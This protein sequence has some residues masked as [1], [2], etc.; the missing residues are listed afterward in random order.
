[1]HLLMLHASL[2]QVC[3]VYVSERSAESAE[4]LAWLL[5]WGDKTTP[6][7][8]RNPTQTKKRRLEWRVPAHTV[9]KIVAINKVRRV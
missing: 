2:S 4:Y 6:I 9:A 7:S 8:T 3:A 5:G 1:V